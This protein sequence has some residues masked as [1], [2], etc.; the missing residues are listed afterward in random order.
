MYDVESLLNKSASS[1][2]PKQISPSVESAQKGKEIEEGDKK[3]ENTTSLVLQAGEQ[4]TTGSKKLA[5]RFKR[6]H[7]LTPIELLNALS[8]NLQSEHTQLHFNYIGLHIRCIKLLREIHDI[9]WEELSY[10]FEWKTEDGMPDKELPR[11]VSWL[12]FHY[13]DDWKDGEGYEEDRMNE[14]TRVLEEVIEAEGARKLE[15]VRE[16]GVGLRRKVYGDEIAKIMETAG[17]SK[18]KRRRPKKKKNAGRSEAVEGAE[19]QIEGSA[20]NSGAL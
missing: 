8:E 12:L 11:F 19:A 20:E 5:E 4:P 9:N 1:Q 3:S 10:K 7:S 14:T 6:S 13:Y 16:I 18:K 15:S 17:S 2:N